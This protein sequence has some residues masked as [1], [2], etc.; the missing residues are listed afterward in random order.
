MIPKISIYRIPFFLLL[1]LFAKP[2]Y[3]E[4]GK[5][6]NIRKET[7][8]PEKS[9]SES[10]SNSNSRSNSDESNSASDELASAILGP[11]IEVLG[12]IV[13]SPYTVPYHYWDEGFSEPLYFQTYPYYMSGS[14]FLSDEADYTQ[15]FE[16]DS[17]VEGKIYRDSVY[18]VGVNL[19]LRTSFR[20]EMQGDYNFL[21]EKRSNGST[22][23]LCLGNANILFR[24]CQNRYLM[25]RSGLGMN[26]LHNDGGDNRYGFN[27]T[28]SLEAY[29]VKPLFLS[30]RI[31]LGNLGDASY[32]R[33]RTSIGYVYKS[34][35]VDAGIEIYNIS[36]ISLQGL[37]LGVKV[38]F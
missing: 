22:D 34:F 16:I 19:N 25:M 32:V 18:G 11:F 37:T 17:S 9:K 20:L 31:D 8:K 30:A 35:E 21:E 23:S 7:K 4:D 28:Y 10:S 13:I 6:D 29:P 33:F 38:Y 1:L 36:G 15:S 27:F 5:L 2:I 3:A 14:G 24:F 26:F 12:Y